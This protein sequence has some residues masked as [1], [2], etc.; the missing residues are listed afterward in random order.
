VVIRSILQQCHDSASPVQASLAL[1]RSLNTEDLD[2]LAQTERS[3]CGGKRVDG[4]EGT[5]L[6]PTSRYYL[7]ATPLSLPEQVKD[8][9]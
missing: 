3:S 5:S 1:L 2:S 9:V 7:T 8:R 4:D 6:L